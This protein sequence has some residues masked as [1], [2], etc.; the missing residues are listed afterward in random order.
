MQIVAESF[1]FGGQFL[2]TAD[3]ASRNRARIAVMGSDRTDNSPYERYASRARA[4]KMLA[5]RTKRIAA[6]TSKTWVSL[7][8]Q[9]RD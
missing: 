8:V 3:T 7:A 5:L 9:I 4:T 6:T 1:Q 2:T